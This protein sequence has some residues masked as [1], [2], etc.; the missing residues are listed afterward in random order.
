MS[1]SGDED[2][3]L[4]EEDVG[5]GWD[6]SDLLDQAAAE[7]AGFSMQYPSDVVDFGHPDPPHLQV[8]PVFTRTV[9]KKGSDHSPDK[10]NG[11]AN[12]EREV[13]E[14]IVL[15]VAYTEHTVVAQALKNGSH[16]GLSS[17]ILVVGSLP[18]FETKET[19]ETISC[20]TIVARESLT[21]LD[22]ADEETAK[23]HYKDSEEPTLNIRNKNNR[24]SK[25]TSPDDAYDEEE[26]PTATPLPQEFLLAIVLGT[27]NARVY[28]AEVLLT[29]S[30]SSDNE[31]QSNL[32][33]SPT[34]VAKNANYVEVLPRDDEDTI[35]MLERYSRR[36]RGEVAVESFVP[37]GK[38]L[39][40]IPFRFKNT[41]G[42]VVKAAYGTYLWI[43]YQDGSLVRLYH[44]AIFPS[45]WEIGASRKIS[46]EELLR[47]VAGF[48]SVAGGAPV[49]RCKLM[50]PPK[51]KSDLQII[52]LPRYHPSP[53]APLSMSSGDMV[54]TDSAAGSFDD[55]ASD[56]E[57]ENSENIEALVFGDKDDPMTPTLVFYTSEDQFVGRI[58]GDDD[59][60][61]IDSGR[62]GDLVSSVVGSVTGIFRWGLGASRRGSASSLMGGLSRAS[63]SSLPDAGSMGTKEGDQI[64]DELPITPFPSLWK[65][66]L[67][68]FAGYEFHDSPR[69]IESCVVDP[70]G[71]L[72][73]LTDSLGRV[74]L[75]DLST[76]QI[77][78]M[79]KGF[80]ET[81][82]HWLQSKAKKGNTAAAA[83]MYPTTHL[84][85]HSRHRRVVEVWRIRQGPRVHL[86][87][88]G[89]GAVLV[90]SPM[91][92]TC[93]NPS[94]CIENFLVQSIVPGGI[95]QMERINIP[96]PC[97]GIVR[98]GTSPSLANTGSSS[99]LSSSRGAS[100]RLQHLRQLLSATDLHY[101]KSDILEA[102]RKIKSLRDLSTALDLIGTA[103]VLEERLG[104]E[105]SSFQK[106]ILEY[107]TETLSEAERNG[108]G[109]VSHSPSAKILSNKLDF[110]SRVS[111][112]FH[113]SKYGRFACLTQFRRTQLV[114]AY[115]V[116]DTFETKETK[117]AEVAKESEAFVEE[118]K[119]WASVYEKVIGS[120][121]R[122]EGEDRKKL[123]LKFSAFAASL[124]FPSDEDRSWGIKQIYFT[125]S[126]RTRGDA[127][128]HIF[129]P[130]LG[131][132]SAGV[133]NNFFDVLGIKDDDTYVQKCFAE[134]FMTLSSTQMTQHGLSLPDSPIN[135]FLEDIAGKQLKDDGTTPLEALFNFCCES[136]DL[137]RSF[138]LA[139]LCLRAVL[140]SAG[141]VENITN[142][143][144]SLGRL[145]FDWEGLLR[146]LRVC[147]LA[148]LRLNGHQ[149]GAMPLSVYNLEV[150]NEF[151][152]YEW[153]A[154]DELAISHRHEEIFIIEEACRMSTYSFDP[155]T[156]QADDPSRVST[157]QKACLAKGE[158]VLE[159]DD[160]GG[161][162][163]LLYFPHH[164]NSM[165]LAAH[166]SLLL[167]SSWLKNPQ[168]LTLLANSL[169]AA[170]ALKEEPALALVVRLELW[171]RVVCP[172][173]RARLFGFV[174]VPE[175]LEDDFEPLLQ[176][177]Q[178][179]R[180]FGRLSL[181]IL[182]LVNQVGWSNDLKTFDWPQSDENDEWWPPLK[183]DFI[184]ER[185]L[186]KVRPLDES[187]RDAHYVIICG[188]LI[189]NDMNA[190]V[191]CVPAIYDCFLSLSI[192][193]PVTVL[194][195]PSPEQ[196]TFLASA[197]LLQARNY[198]GPPL[199][200]FQLG[201]LAVL[202]EKWGFPLSTLRTLYLLA[203]Y[204][205]GKDTIVDDLLTRAFTQ[206]DATRFLD[207]GLDIV[208]RRLDTFF[209]S[210]F[211]K[212]RH[213]REVM[214]VL[215]ADLCDWIQQQAAMGDE[216]PVWEFPEPHMGL[217]L[218]HTLA[219]RLLSLSKKANVDTTLRV[220]IHS[221]AVLS[222]TLLKEVEEVRRQHKV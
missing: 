184:L 88:V 101:T 165:M 50:L 143:K 125:D 10:E 6:C 46:L 111:L 126:S 45:V 209:R 204:E 176:Q 219:L 195:S 154:R 87:Q 167:A 203:L 86:S 77:V 122:D 215:D 110:Y 134:W 66:P 218:T 72:A 118:A 150:E 7:E 41:A 89:R 11:D 164:N 60:R 73:A 51:R 65:P 159:G 222:G 177:R 160:M 80:R 124:V 197:I 145:T 1:T 180:D 93:D 127:L 99:A 142:G 78:R 217:S 146:K 137:V 13:E 15:V 130:L 210:D 90:S 30:L 42:P 156:E 200:Q 53:L 71:H 190:L 57:E 186:R 5:G 52:P 61:S 214:G 120:S 68:L 95:N 105:G 189:S 100:L 33:F 194:P 44:A 119:G 54:D 32:S 23:N 97:T 116:I 28:S 151:S 162:S 148:T 202:G 112:H 172:V 132:F 21:F 139:T 55:G 121:I 18:V 36:H 16:P 178:W 115:D 37:K 182:D 192:F 38:V 161:T 212:R 169:E 47:P 67:Q 69:E 3:H 74:L 198:S 141:R 138:L 123:R 49:V 193:N 94:N 109:E 174:D 185:A 206:I 175:L 91:V 40:L 70:N 26:D 98:N 19:D 17:E 76:K 188:L 103:S 43:T 129:K 48:D 81:T 163:L 114:K 84:A 205:F 14:E 22:E 34:M 179:L 183:P 20:L 157:I 4:E 149:L 216:G 170:Q 140:K 8:F 208:C 133:L 136:V 104:V 75:I 83:G 155:S 221:L 153:L 131:W 31:L 102:V 106:S 168:Q 196:D 152:V 64:K 92:G 181:R 158:T 56:G 117:Q 201:E 2:L 63:I 96:Q 173:Y 27:S 9:F 29:V 59:M 107:C 144:V 62:S 39:S 199:E 220:K 128:I 135:R 211:M 147:L 12:E 213:M 35:E 82:C 79:W 207:G 25:D 108:N 191:P 187:S 58:K 166:R 24:V 85:I 113:C 171:T